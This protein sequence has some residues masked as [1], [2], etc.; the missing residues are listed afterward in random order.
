MNTLRIHRKRILIFTAALSCAS[1]FAEPVA[2]FDETLTESQILLPD[3]TTTVLGDSPSAGMDAV[4]D[5]SGIVLSDS[6]SD[7]LPR[8]PD[9]SIQDFEDEPEADFSSDEEKDI[10]AQ[11]LI[12]AGYPGYFTGDF[13][14]Y[15]NS[16]ENPFSLRFS[17]DSSYGY[18]SHSAGE[19]F[20]DSSTALDGSKTFTWNTVSLESAAKYS[21]QTYGL[22]GVCAP[23]FYDMS[24]ITVGLDE[25]LKWTL[26]KGFLLTAGLQGE[27][28]SRYAGVADGE[29]STATE[30]ETGARSLNFSP[31]VRLSWAGGNFS[32]G[33][34]AAYTFEDFVSR[35][36]FGAD[37]LWRDAG[38]HAGAS[39]AVVVGNAIGSRISAIPPFTVDFGGEWNVGPSSRVLSV[40]VKGGL[41]SYLPL[42]SELETLYLFSAA[43]GA[44]SETSDWYAEVKASVPVLS[45][46]TVDF[47]GGFKA[48]AFGNGVWE[49]DY[50]SVSDSG[51]GIYSFAPLSRVH[52]RT[53]LEVSYVYKFLTAKA[54]WNSN[55]GRYVPAAEIPFTIGFS[56]IAQD[57]KSRWGADLSFMQPLGAGVDFVPV[58]DTS[59]FYRV[60]DSMRLALQIDDVIKLLGASDRVYASSKY[61]MKAGSAT[62]LVRFL[63]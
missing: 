52:V 32:A 49:P 37:F 24:Y 45:S 42:R 21:M 34:D 22:Q 44:L 38:Y 5:F 61:M 50:R 8:M 23:Y 17:H 33:T 63:F 58:I 2:D 12:G 59:A 28:Y 35:G 26:P 3:V 43:G 25:T 51:A 16:G 7:V 27:W 30:K 39:V 62:V 55:W 13:S 11:G 15:K 1:V 10:Y 46:L 41:D 20:F 9:G 18:G 48:T 53:D 14:V 31:G 57:E 36:Q 47:S 54:F 40:E 56:V 19:G 60:N 29:M 4:P 6:N